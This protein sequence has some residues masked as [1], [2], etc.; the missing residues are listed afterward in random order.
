[1]S[2]FPKIDKAYIVERFNAVVRDGLSPGV[3]GAR[4]DSGNRPWPCA[5]VGGHGVWGP[6]NEPNGVSE[7]DIPDTKVVANVFAALNTIAKRF[8]YVRVVSYSHT[9]TGNLGYTIADSGTAHVSAGYGAP[10]S[11]GDPGP[12]VGQVVRAADLENFLQTLR[13]QVNAVRGSYAGIEACS[14]CHAS[15]HAS[16][17][18]SRGRR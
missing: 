2:Q 13:G 9:I 5:F 8:A 1:M 7:A 18:G 6:R 3:N 10:G 15:C 17:H 16:C 11:V 4:W 12:G 14:H